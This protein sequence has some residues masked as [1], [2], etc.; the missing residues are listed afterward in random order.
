[1]KNKYSCWFLAIATHTWLFYAQSFGFNSLVFAILAVLL[2]FFEQPTLIRQPHWRIASMAYIMA[3][4]ATAWHASDWAISSYFVAF[5]VLVGMKFDARSNVLVGL[6]NGILASNIFGFVGKINLF[7]RDISTALAKYLS[8]LPRTK[9]ATFLLPALITIVFYF[10]YSFANPD[11]RIQLSWPELYLNYAL[12]FSIAWAAILL[13]PLFFESGLKTITQSEIEIS[14]DL[15]RSKTNKSKLRIPTLGLLNENK[16]AVLMFAML[17]ILICLFLIFNCWQL[18]QP[19]T[20]GFS[21]QVHESF[22]TLIISIILAIVLIL[23]FFRGNQNFYHANH[24]L[25]KLAHLWIILNAVLALFTLYKNTIYVEAFGLTYKRIGVYIGL[26]LTI[27]GLFITFIKV[28]RVKTNWYLIRQNAWI[29]YCFFI[30]YG[31]IDWDRVIV[32]FN[33]HHAKYTDYEYI[34]SLGPTAIPQL[35]ASNEKIKTLKEFSGCSEHIYREYRN[36]MFSM[37]KSDWRSQTIDYLWLQKS[38]IHQ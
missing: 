18:F 29:V 24:T 38:L 34:Y 25:I 11:F 35:L 28:V 30:G 33:L 17:N 27:I 37:A 6:L 2:S 36:L 21:Q 9:A 16:Q 13:A 22:Y 3:G 12:I 5:W 15:K 26:I 14:S 1:M 10:L 32:S 20:K 8:F 23:Y 19:S 7:I 4:L 31:L